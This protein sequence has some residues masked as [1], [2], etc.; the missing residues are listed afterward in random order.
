MFFA[1]ER[2]IPPNT[3]VSAPYHM[4]LPITEGVITRVVIRWRYGVAW[5]GGCRVCH[6]GFQ[7][8]PLSIGEW[9]TSSHHALEF[10]DQY[11]VDD[12]PFHL[13]VYAYN[14]DD[15]FSHRLFVGVEILR[16]G[17]SKDLAAFLQW[18]SIGGAYGTV[19]D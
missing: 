18:V 11:A 1:L 12:V 14:T 6:G 2:P 16:P 13:D 8:Y 10:A 9:L 15:S 5:L 3:P 4:E 19:S 17:V 7:L